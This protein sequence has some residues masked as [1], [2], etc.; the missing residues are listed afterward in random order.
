MRHTATELRLPAHEDVRCLNLMCSKVGGGCSCRVALSLSRM[1]LLRV[2]DLSAN[3][4]PDLPDSI[5]HAQGIREVYLQENKLTA[6]TAFIRAGPSAFQQLEVLDLRKNSFARVYRRKA[7]VDE[8]QGA[9]KEQEEGIDLSWLESLPALKQV[10]LSDNPLCT[11][12]ASVDLLQD[13]ITSQGKLQF[14]RQA[15][16]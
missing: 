6:L 1:P 5:G 9:G 7:L 10:R 12:K 16:E 8:A 3:A 14:D 13:S 2:L 4:L 15:D 11:D